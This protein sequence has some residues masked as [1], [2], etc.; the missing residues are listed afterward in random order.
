M[1]LQQ[2]LDRYKRQL[3]QYLASIPQD[4]NTIS[5][6]NHLETILKIPAEI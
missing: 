2:P 6:S 3:Q 4:T 5:M 1:P